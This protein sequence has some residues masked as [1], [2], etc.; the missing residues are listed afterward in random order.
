MR[1]KRYSTEQIVRILRE[2]DSG[3]KTSAVCRKHNISEQTFYRWRK[4]YGDL[5]VPEAKKLRELEKQNAKLKKLLA[6]AML[7]IELLKE[8]N[9]KNF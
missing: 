3:M 4:K 2:A 1:G 9:S 6:E 7:D 8:V 5:G